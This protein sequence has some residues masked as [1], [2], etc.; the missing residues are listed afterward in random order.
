MFSHGGI[1]Y[2]GIFQNR[3]NPKD[4]KIPDEEPDYRIVQ[5]LTFYRIL[6]RLYSQRL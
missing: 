6:Y 3:V 5:N 2:K 4:M 1:M